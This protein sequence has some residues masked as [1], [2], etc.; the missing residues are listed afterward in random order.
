[1]SGFEKD[2][3]SLDSTFDG[4]T[5]DVYPDEL[6]SYV[7]REMSTTKR[8]PAL[9]CLLS[10]R[11]SGEDTDTGVAAGVQFVHAGLDATRRV[12]DTGGWEGAGVEP[13]EEDMVLLAAD[14]LV[15]VGFDHLL[16][17]YEAA[18]RL[19]NTFGAT[20]ARALEAE[21]DTERFEHVSG[22]F[23]EAYTTAA[24]LGSDEPSDGIVALAESLAVAD[25]AEASPSEAPSA[26]DPR[27]TGTRDAAY[28]AE[29]FEE[30]GFGGYVDAV[31]D[32]SALG[33]LGGAGEKEA[34]VE[35]QD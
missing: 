34:G 14:V 11:V 16:D 17:E 22:Y 3:R 10:S 21:T 13:V 35:A 27:A 33:S 9:L 18:T 7:R 4:V 6:R 19:V 23:V 24:R 26:G 29:G 30:R 8:T 15:T 32:E 5:E 1:M 2:R 12:L 31:R 28:L 25:Y 20:K